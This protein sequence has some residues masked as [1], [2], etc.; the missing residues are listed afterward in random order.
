MEQ[1]PRHNNGN[2]LTVT[3]FSVDW[4]AVT[5]VSGGHTLRSQHSWVKT[6]GSAF[7]KV[8]TTPPQLSGAM[9]VFSQ[10]HKGNVILHVLFSTVEIDL[11]LTSDSPSFNKTLG[12]WQQK[13]Y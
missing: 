3:H 5:E 13:K 10:P 2:A 8:E 12:S 7:E 6:N 4:N 1:R 11:H 9:T